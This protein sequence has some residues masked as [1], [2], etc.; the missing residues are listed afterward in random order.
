M[1]DKGKLYLIPTPIGN[2]KDISQRAI[3]TLQNVDLLLCE[4]TRHSQKLL[5]HFNIKVKLVSY[6][7]HNEKKRSENVIEWLNQGLNIGLITDAGMP[8]ISDPGSIVVDLVHKSNLEVVVIPGANAALTA[9]V[10]SGFDS[11]SFQFIGFLPRQISKKK[12]ALMATA[13]YPGLTI[14]YESPNRLLD[15]L[16]TMQ[17]LFPD[18]EIFIAREISKIHEEHFRGS[19]D[20]AIEH[21]SDRTVKGEI[22]MVLN[23]YEIHKSEIDVESEIKELLDKGIKKSEAVKQIAEKYG[24]NKNEIYKKSLEI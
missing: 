5:N 19:I 9:V 12:D 4:D 24:L 16:K 7:E 1:T 2:L 3:E 23:S 20:Q 15:T 11:S 10:L 6:H 18:R 13:E 17:E 22:A 14:I 21:Y 8:G